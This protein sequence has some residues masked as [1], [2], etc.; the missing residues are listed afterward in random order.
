MTRRTNRT[1]ARALLTTA[2]LA[3][4]LALA[5]AA[6]GP[7]DG[8]E[9]A[10]HYDPIGKRD[11]FRPYVDPDVPTRTGVELGP[12]QSWNLDQLRVV[13]V[14]LDDEEGPRAL[15][16]DPAGLGHIVRV[17]DL[18]GPRWGSVTQIGASGLVITERRRA[19]D[20]RWFV[21][22]QEMPLPRPE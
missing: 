7:D 17:G 21:H 19:D 5:P 15:V 1:G 9:P 10:Y 20:G 3:T 8:E 18:V 4:S 22:Q 11:P 2:L 12:L 16:E 6:A 13:G 14:V